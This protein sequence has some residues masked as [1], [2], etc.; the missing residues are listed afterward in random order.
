MDFVNTITQLVLTLI[1]TLILWS[2]GYNNAPLFLILS[3]LIIL[4]I[5][6][7][8][9]QNKTV[10]RLPWKEGAADLEIKQKLIGQLVFG[11]IMIT[12]I[13][14]IRPEIMGAPSFQALPGIGQ[15]EIIYGRTF[16]I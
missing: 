2:R 9:R 16:K 11:A 7:G 8:A 5:A 1:I 3:T 15:T 14:I 6:W 10:L 4:L 12:A 13:I